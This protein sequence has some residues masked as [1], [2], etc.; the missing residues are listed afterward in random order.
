MKRNEKA[1]IIAGIVGLATYV[2]I[3]DPDFFIECILEGIRKSSKKK[4]E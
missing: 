4:E 2:A 3:T 1:P